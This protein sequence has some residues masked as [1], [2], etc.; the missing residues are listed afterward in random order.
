MGVQISIS[1]L[2]ITMGISMLNLCN[3]MNVTSAKL[4]HPDA[5]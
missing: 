1:L 5:S 4:A 3:D 2:I